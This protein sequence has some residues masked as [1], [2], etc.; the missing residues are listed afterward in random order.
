LDFLLVGILYWVLIGISA[1]LL[2]GGLWKKSWKMVLWSG[3]ALIPPTISL[4]L[5]GAEGWFILS[6]L[7]PLAIFGLAIY[8]K[9]KEN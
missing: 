9:G 2:I 6:G 8:T 4:Y 7:V 1:L 5:G 3:I